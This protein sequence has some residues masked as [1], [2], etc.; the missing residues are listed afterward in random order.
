MSDQ[1]FSTDLW[2]RDVAKLSEVS[3]SRATE[4]LIFA[5]LELLCRP[6]HRASKT[7][8]PSDRQTI[9]KHPSSEKAAFVFSI[10]S[11]P[12]AQDHYCLRIDFFDRPEAISVPG[13]TVNRA[14]RTQWSESGERRFYVHDNA[15]TV[16]I[17]GFLRDII[18]AD[19]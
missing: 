11:R 14:P 4:L 7:D 18:A 12:E 5:A 16:V 1:V 10:V 15:P 2:Y 13:S 8:S 9:F 19:R 17:R 3:K 6:Y